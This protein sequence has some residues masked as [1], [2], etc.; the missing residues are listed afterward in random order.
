ME[1]GKGLRLNYGVRT[2][3]RKEE[4]R[5]MVNNVTYWWEG[6]KDEDWKYVSWMLGIMWFV[7]LVRTLFKMIEAKLKSWLVLELV[8]RSDAEKSFWYSNHAGEDDT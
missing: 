7:S 8:G 1:N 3:Q 4:F 5:R 2:D 6:K